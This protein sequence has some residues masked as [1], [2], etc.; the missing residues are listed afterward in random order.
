MIMKSRVLNFKKYRKVKFDSYQTIPVP[1]PPLSKIYLCYVQILKAARLPSF[2]DTKTN[3]AYPT[4]ATNNQLFFL[5]NF[6]LLYAIQIQNLPISGCY[7]LQNDIDLTRLEYQLS[8]RLFTLITELKFNIM[9]INPNNVLNA[10]NTSLSKHAIYDLNST[11]TD[12]PRSEFS[13]DLLS[14]LIGCSRNQLLYQQKKIN[15]AYSIKVQQLKQKC[16]ALQ[17]PQ[18]SAELFWSAQHGN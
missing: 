10:F 9:Q 1:Y 14:K 15:D 3:L 8:T 12:K 13:L 4:T 6:L 17:H 2:L 16:V 11:H 5:D 18:P 7:I